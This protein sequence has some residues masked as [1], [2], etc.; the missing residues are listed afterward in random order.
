MTPEPVSSAPAAARRTLSP[1]A[2]LAIDFGP[3]VVFFVSY[4]LA[5]IGLLPGI[6]ADRAIYLATE[7]TMVASVVAVVISLIV[8]RTI[9]A[10]LAVTS[11]MVILFG[12]IT[13]ALNNPTFI[14][15]KPTIVYAVYAVALL[16]GAAAGRPLLK[17]ILGQG[18]PPMA[19]TGW[20]RLSRNFG[21][22]FMLMGALNEV[23]WRGFSEKIWVD[24][25]VWGVTA[26]TALFMASQYPLL[27]RY[28]EDEPATDAERPERVTPPPPG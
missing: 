12:G 4:N 27:N 1:V 17:Y 28:L 25:D 3:L 10:A 24:Y 13:I 2:R 22:F 15:I 20:M 9:S 8:N 7:A 19:H 16:G 11:G 6:A 26:L 5:R 23:M 21:L 14:K 18:F